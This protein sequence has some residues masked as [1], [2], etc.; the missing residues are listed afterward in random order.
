ML[1][2]Q[3]PASTQL[4]H[5]CLSFVSVPH[6]CSTSSSPV[7]TTRLH[8]QPLASTHCSSQ[9]LT[10][11][12]ASNH[13][14]IIRPPCQH[15]TPACMPTS[16]SHVTSEELCQHDSAVV[17]SHHHANTRQP[18]RCP[19]AQP[20][21]NCHFNTQLPGRLSIHQQQSIRQS[22]T[23]PT[24]Y[25]RANLQPSRRYP[26]AE[27]VSS[28]LTSTTM[29]H[30]QPPTSTHISSQCLTAAPAFSHPVTIQPPCQHPTPASTLTANNHTTSRQLCH[31]A[32][33]FVSS[34][35]HATSPLPTP[36]SAPPLNRQ[37]PSH[38][39]TSNQP[40]HGL[41]PTSSGESRRSLLPWGAHPSH[42]GLSQD[43][44]S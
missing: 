43:Q 5:R 19:T 1:H 23:H 34:T 3:P 26:S 31:H 18:C 40:R 29:P 30:R 32:S 16:N 24:S 35:H 37:P 11:V 21:S 12:P 15:P 7:S 25:G 8:H 33:A 44:H 27:S 10:A 2:H 4:S 14:A 20:T 39:Q 41:P 42:P 36:T 38:L 9:C 13:P 6:C 17:L 28:S 22:L